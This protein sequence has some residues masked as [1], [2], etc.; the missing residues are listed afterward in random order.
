MSQRQSHRGVLVRFDG[1]YVA[2]PGSKNSY[3]AKLERARLFPT[4]EA[5]ERERCVNNEYVREA[6][7]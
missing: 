6:L 2:M 3:T 4:R 7:P 5:A 1:K